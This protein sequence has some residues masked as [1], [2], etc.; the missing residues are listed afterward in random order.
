MKEFGKPIDNSRSC[1]KNSVLF[2]DTVYKYWCIELFCSSFV[3]FLTAIIILQ[4]ND[5]ADRRT[6]N[7]IPT[8]IGMIYITNQRFTCS[9]KDHPFIRG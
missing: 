6:K 9:Q 2:L 1:D 7:N 5:L 4:A 8:S 3:E